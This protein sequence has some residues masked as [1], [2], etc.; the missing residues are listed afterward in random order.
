MCLKGGRFLWVCLSPTLPLF[1]ALIPSILWNTA[2]YGRHCLITVLEIVFYN[3]IDDSLPIVFHIWNGP[4]LNKSMR[5]KSTFCQTR[6]NLLCT[7]MHI[8]QWFISFLCHTK[9]VWHKIKK[10]IT[11]HT[12]LETR[13]Y[14]CWGIEA[15][16]I[17]FWFLWRLASCNSL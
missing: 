10:Y 3:F 1:S 16:N 5:K 11:N 4:T 7:L 13:K 14:V 8:N 15:T 12:C 2:P 9:E 6:Y 17:F